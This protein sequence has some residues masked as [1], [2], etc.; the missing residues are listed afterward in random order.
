MSKKIAI[1]GD[2][3]AVKCRDTAWATLVTRRLNEAGGDYEEVNLA[4]SGSSLTVSGYPQVLPKALALN[5]ALVIIEHGVNDNSYGFSLGRFL[6]AY[7]ETVRQ[8]KAALPRAGVLCLTACPSWTPHANATAEWLNQA[9]VGI[10]EIAALEGTLLAHVA[11]AVADHSEAFP[12]RLHPDERGHQLIAAAVLE[13]LQTDKPRNERR[14]DCVGQG[15]GLYRSCGYVFQALPGIIPL[16]W[17]DFRDISRISFRYRSAYE[18]LIRTPFDSPPDDF[19][20]TLKQA[21]STRII[22]GTHDA[23]G[24]TICRRCFSVPPADDWVAAAIEPKV[25]NSRT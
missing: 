12:D 18:V 1:I 7:R 10:Q 25:E 8:I 11:R 4:V 19:T 22:T 13:A 16:G 24:Q 14:F 20:V 17:I 3:I 9:N 23:P 21:A 5:P 15:A 2:S 6:W